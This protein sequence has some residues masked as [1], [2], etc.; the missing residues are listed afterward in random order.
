MPIVFGVF[1]AKLDVRGANLMHNKPKSSRK[2][3]DKWSPFLKI[4]A[5]GKLD[6][7]SILEIGTSNNKT[8]GFGGRLVVKQTAINKSIWF[9]VKLY[10]IRVRRSIDNFSFLEMYP[11]SAIMTSSRRHLYRGKRKLAEGNT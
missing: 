4:G 7:G 1:R 9:V 10:V 5:L 2:I 3:V 11:L 6:L 8:V